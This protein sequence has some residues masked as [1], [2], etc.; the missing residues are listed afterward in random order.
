[1]EPLLILHAVAAVCAPALMRRLGRNGFPVLAVPPACG[2]G[3]A[4]WV[5]LNG[6]PAGS[7]HP[8]APTL[9]FALSFR[10]DALALLMTFLVTGVGALVLLYCSRYFDA[11]EEGLG[12]F[13]GVL[14]AFAGAMLGLV[15]A[16]NL[17]LLYVFWE[18]TT[19]FSYLLIGQDPAS[20]T[21]RRAAMQALTVTTFGGLTMLA[22]MVVLGEA[23]GTYEISRIVADPPAGGSVPVAMALIL[24]GA[25][26]KSAIFPFS[27]W[28]PAAMAAPTPVSA[29]LHAAAMVKA[30]VYLIARLGPA[31]GGLPAWQLIVVPLGLL[32]MVLGG[33]RALREHD[34]KR[35]LAYG[36][37]SQ[38]GFLTVLFGAATR[39]TAIA[40]VAMLLAH[41]LFKA[42]LFLVVGVI[43]HSTG[44]RDLRELSGL[45]H[46]APWLC[47]TSVAAAASMAGI[48]PFL[49]FVGKEAAFES[50]LTGRTADTVTLVGVVVGS[51]LTAGYSLRFL[52]GAFGDRPGREP[53]PAHGSAAATFLPPALLAVLG[54]VAA[55]FAGRYGHAMESYTDTFAGPGHGTHLALWTGA[56]VPLLLSA[57]ALAGGVLLLLAGPAVERTGRILRLVDSGHVY[58]SVIRALDRSALQ[59]TGVTQRGSLPDYLMIALVSMAGIGGFSLLYGPV[60]DVRLDVVPWERVEQPVIGVLLIATALVAPRVRSHI[61]L[62]LLAGVTGYGVALLFLVHGSPDLALTQFLTETLS[63]VVFVLV[64]RRLPVG[65][66]EGS[67]RVPLGVRVA[68][69]VV[70]GVMIVGAGMLAASARTAMPVGRLMAGAAEESGASNIVSALLVD[71]RAW[72]TM[73]ESSVIVVLTLGVTSLVFLRRRTYALERPPAEARREDRTHWLAATLPAGEQAVVLEVVARL[74]FHTVMLISLFLLFTGH[75]SVGGGF[76]GGIVAGLALVIRYLAGGR[77]ELAVAAPVDAGVLIGLGL[78]LSTVTA[79]WG[80]LATGAPLDMLSADLAVPLIGELHLSTVLLFDI[81]IYVTV[82]GMAQDVLRSL[83]AELD[84]QIDAEEER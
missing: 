4:L 9:G 31:F 66:R 36:T 42:S 25:L 20:R 52:W 44:T 3:Y 82:V 15:V 35:L 77:Y 30:G 23:A 75:S 33:W 47:A 48:P 81:G 6:V 54:L 28:L 16:D 46:S 68:L 60:R 41:A 50:L 53:V 14:V 29:Y 83:G 24:V 22:G 71:I 49:G 5:A 55:P 38:L 76:A 21:S 39:D 67:P 62:A 40:G 11:G 34:L 70:S 10:V 65:P 1:M 84:R 74:T 56:P 64:L 43:D 37:V 45:R 51:V 18:L 57:V 58:W 59:L 12:R 8:Y 27:M 7:E 80:L 26:S 61:V 69:G 19:V 63:L 78:L 13:G 79:L 73:G 2:L 17:L 32:T 72:D